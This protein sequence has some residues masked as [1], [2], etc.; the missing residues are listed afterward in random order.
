MVWCWAATLEMI[1][2]AHRKRVSQ[3]SIVEQVYGRA[4]EAPIDRLSLLQSIDRT[5]TDEEGDEFQVTSGI[6]DLA[7]GQATISNVDI[8]DEFQAGRP[9]IYCNHT[10][11]VAAYGAHYSSTGTPYSPVTICQ[12]MVADPW[13]PRVGSHRQ[14][15]LCEMVP[16]FF[17]G[18]Q[19][20]FVATVEVS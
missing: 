4:V 14:L 9:I 13:P 12:V 6:F 18:G 15:Q 17:P 3:R 7:T 20:T 19:L 11:M 1:F 16:A 5:Y 2:A 8:I 10:H